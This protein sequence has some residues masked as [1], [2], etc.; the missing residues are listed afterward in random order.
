MSG[1]VIVVGIGFYNFFEGIVVF[2]GFMKGLW[3]GISFV[4]VI[5]FYNIL[6]GVVVVFFVYFVIESWW[7][8]F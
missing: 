2:L 1:I 7:K 8:V 5:V 4:C 3:V 6:E